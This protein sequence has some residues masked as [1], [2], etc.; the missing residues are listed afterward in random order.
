MHWNIRFYFRT[1]PFG[2]GFYP[3]IEGKGYVDQQ[4]RRSC[5]MGLPMN[6]YSG[7]QRC[8]WQQKKNWQQMQNGKQSD[9]MTKTEE[10]IC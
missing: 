10:K 6:R 8:F 9:K 2:G 1:E 4:I 7:R 3:C 5:I